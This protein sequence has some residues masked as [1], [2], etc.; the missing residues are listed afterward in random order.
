MNRLEQI[1]FAVM[2]GA[3]LSV[4]AG[5]EREPA[6]KPPAPAEGGA[7][8][9]NRVDIGPAVR[10]NLGI[11]FAKVESRRV[12]RTLRVPGRFELSPTARR[13]YRV[14]AAGSVELLVTQYQAVEA[15]A[16][17]YRLDSPR[18]RELQSELAD[19]DAAIILAQAAA[20]SVAPLLEAHEAHHAAIEKSLALWAERAAALEKLQAAGAA[21]GED[22]AQARASVASAQ[23]DLAEVSE[24]HVELSAKER[25][26]TA[27]LGA[28]RARRGILLEMASSLTGRPAEE[29][30]E[31]E[32]NAPRWR[33]MRTVE[34]RA[35]SA[36]VVDAVRVASGSYVDQHAAVIDTV[37]PDQVRFRAHGLQSD[38]GRLSDGLPAH[39][40]P[41]QGGSLSAAGA[42]A[43]VLTMAP[44]AD[45]ERR[46]IELVVIPAQS[47][48]LPAWARAGVSAHLEVVVS[49]EGAD[50]LAIP[51]ACIARD[52]TRSV[53]FR[54]DPTDPDKAIRVEADLG[55][56]DGRWVAVRSGVAEGNEIVLD[57][58]YQLMVATSGSIT[59]GGHFHSDG[60]F[61]EGDE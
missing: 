56:D 60:T 25:E 26:A 30:A 23:A 49:G 12:A 24:T 59:P 18:W 44:T 15:G 22:V 14:P 35:Q 45:A 20:E 10:Q 50:E 37:Q 48:A 4:W 43:G 41:P 39:I 42:I 58:V 36:G 7:A 53:F 38:L 40:V 51:L 29:L 31:I 16:P 54:R 9:T 27:Q 1:V 11:T 28:A 8:M 47:A 5:C 46:T 52:G 2:M 57:G 3:G 6:A 55:V 32:N 17:L 61:H 13:E 21:R 19:A 34:V 33:G